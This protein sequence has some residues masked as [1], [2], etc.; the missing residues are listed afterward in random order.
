MLVT[1]LSEADAYEYVD[2]VVKG[3]LS[4]ACINS[5]SSTTNSGDRD[6]VE[7]LKA[8]LDA[9]AIMAKILAVDVAYH[10]HHMKA[11]AD[12]YLKLIQGLKTAVPR[13]ST[14]FFS[15][16]TGELKTS[17]FGAEYWLEN[18]VST[19]RFSDAISAS[20]REFPLNASSRGLVAE[21]SKFVPRGLPEASNE[22]PV[23]GV[24]AVTQ[25]TTMDGRQTSEPTKGYSNGAA[26]LSNIAQSTANL[27]DVKYQRC[28]K[29]Q[30]ISSAA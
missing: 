16:V 19:V 27:N 2:R 13:K 6:A 17:G 20:C 9:E 28:L 4:L 15:A 30:F 23:N 14:Q 8:I 18:L 25:A 1:A 7:A 10:S 24:D 12:H 21:R 11:V 5:P 22:A 26:V 3:R 29:T